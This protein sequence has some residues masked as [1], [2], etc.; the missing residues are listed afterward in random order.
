MVNMLFKITLHKR[1]LK[2]KNKFVDIYN[3]L[4]LYFNNIFIFKKYLI[5][6]YLI[7]FIIFIIY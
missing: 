2:L 1:N 6:K 7:F 3:D 4:F 5:F